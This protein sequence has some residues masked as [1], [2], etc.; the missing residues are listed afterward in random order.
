MS[1]PSAPDASAER[2]RALFREGQADARPSDSCPAPE[3]I[4]EAARGS[5]APDDTTRLVEHSLSCPACAFA[6]RLARELLA[7]VEP[8]P[9]QEQENEKEEPVLVRLPRRRWIVSALSGLAVAATALLV[10]RSSSAPVYRAEEVK[11]VSLVAESSLPREQFLLRWAALGTGTRYSVN[12][13]TPDLNVLFARGGLGEAQLQVPPAAL[14]KLP[15]GSAV[16][17]RVTALLV[18]GRRIESTAFLTAVR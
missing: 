15:A 16:V 12:V 13:A 17:W 4:F 2:L 5:L 18:D 7:E 8:A 1:G 10:V 3:Q 9:G 14:S 6:F 11:I